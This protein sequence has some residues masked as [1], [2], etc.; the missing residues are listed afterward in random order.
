MAV[1][2]GFYDSVAHDRQYSSIQFGQ[3]FDGV[4]RDGIFTTVGTKFAVT[5]SASKDLNILVGV[6]RAWFNHT[7]IYN[8]APYLLAIPTPEL[9]LNRIDAVVIDVNSDEDVRENTIKIVKGTPA[10]VP[11]E[12]VMINELNHHQYPLA[13][14]YVAK[15]ATGIRDANITSAI[16]SSST[17]FVSGILSTVSADLYYRQWRDE[18]KRF[19][20][21]QTADMNTTNTYWKSLWDEYYASMTEEIRANYDAWTAEW[22][23]WSADQKTLM[24]NK[25]EEYVAL[26]QAWF[27]TYTTQNQS[28]QRAFMTNRENE[29]RTWFNGIK[30]LMTADAAANLANLLT[31]V[32]AKVTELEAF[33]ENITVNR[34]AYPKITDG[35]SSNDAI[36]DSNGEPILGRVVFKIL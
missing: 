19:Y 27:L 12:P 31:A 16:G 26:W 5:E 34:E 2:S 1:T 33:A 14:V 29:F 30:G 24:T 32:N 3:I 15:E 18:W 8:D 22:T 9:L 36:L 25:E 17:P 21:N 13:Y 4:I 6:G 28:E 7:W 11:T 35:S 10:T 20:E 23:T